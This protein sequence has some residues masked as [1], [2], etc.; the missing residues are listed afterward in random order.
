[1]LHESSPR[2][3]LVLVFVHHAVTPK[4]HH[5]KSG[6]F[7]VL[8]LLEGE[9]RSMIQEAHT[10]RFLLSEWDTRCKRPCQRAYSMLRLCEM[11]QQVRGPD[12]PVLPA[13]ICVRF[14]NNAVRPSHS[15]RGGTREGAVETPK[16]LPSSNVTRK[17]V[18]AFVY[19]VSVVT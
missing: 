8:L 18:S 6:M 14:T 10:L 9:R 11:Y 12:V 7:K 19:F 3:I 15:D 5:T 13:S 4:A 16:P 1:M 2:T 17:A